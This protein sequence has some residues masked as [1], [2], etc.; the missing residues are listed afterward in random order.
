MKKK[1][2]KPV[3]YIRARLK[4]DILLFSGDFNIGEWDEQNDFNEKN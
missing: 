4:G 3:I 1:Y 2:Y